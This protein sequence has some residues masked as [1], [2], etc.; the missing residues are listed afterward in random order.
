MKIREYETGDLSSLDNNLCISEETFCRDSV[1][2]M[3]VDSGKS[4]AEISH[5]CNTFQNKEMTEAIV[6]HG[7]STQSLALEKPNACGLQG[8]GINEPCV[9]GREPI[10][11]STFSKGLKGTRVKDS[12]ACPEDTE[13]SVT[14]FKPMF[15]DIDWKNT[16]SSQECL[17]RK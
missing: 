5:R 4:E 13:Y 16:N 12:D 6:L 1:T 15:R 7:L 11:Q 10:L 2:N 14:A 8:T 3:T 9:I 17:K